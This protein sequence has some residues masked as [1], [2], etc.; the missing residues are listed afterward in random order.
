MYLV[1][2]TLLMPILIGMAGLGTEA[3]LWL[4]N[5]QRIQAAAD[6]A[7]VSAAIAYSNSANIQTQANAIAAQYG[8]V[9]GINGVTVTVNDPPIA[10]TYGSYTGYPCTGGN[11]FPC[12]IEVTITQQQFPLFSGHW[13]NTLV[14]NKAKGIAIAVPKVCM[15]ALDPSASGAVTV[16]LLAAINLTGCSLF[17]NSTSSSSIT[18][19][20]LAAITATGGGTI[21]TMGNVTNFFGVISPTPITGVASPIPDPYSFLGTPTPGSPISST[22]TAPSGCPPSTTPNLTGV[23]NNPGHYCGVTVSTG[24]TLLANAAAGAYTF[25]SGI[26]VNGGTVT[27]GSATYT[28]NGNITVS[29]GTVT[30]GPGTYNLNGNI[31][32]S[33]SGRV[34]F[35]GGGITTLFCPNTVANCGITVNIGGN[36]TLNP[37]TY[38]LSGGNTSGAG[39]TVT[40]GGTLTSNAGSYTMTMSGAT[41][42]TGGT[43]SY[44]SGTY[45]MQALSETAAN[46]TF[47]GGTYIFNSNSTTTKMLSLSGS[48]LTG[49]GVTLVFTSLTGLYD[50]TA[51]QVQLGSTISLTAPTSGAT[52]GI[53][54]FGDN[55]SNASTKPPPV[56]TT[57]F[58]F[59]TASTLNVTGTVYLPR[60]SLTV[61][62]FDFVSEKCT[63][64][65]ADKIYVVGL[66]NFGDQCS[67]GLNSRIASPTS[68]T[69]VE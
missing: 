64:I 15:L 34:T 61:A 59:D 21:G 10:P 48:T 5:H 38:Y 19:D 35:S 40:S 65:I 14:N 46:V 3:G 2:M 41:S 28:L 7:A 69:L 45:T 43:L 11:S 68:P 42:V 18:V 20:F 67:T 36:V 27:F 32:V 12:A 4:L 8:F 44:G 62:A 37:G 9:N 13:L 33:G 54:L 24:H 6:S 55:G 22:Y 16:E 57:N 50:A 26:T 66:A 31:T 17:S 23:L 58:T 49:T 47:N 25:A 52:Q 53:V 1:Y 60:S 56:G 39:I 63:Q 30:F 29:S 51:M